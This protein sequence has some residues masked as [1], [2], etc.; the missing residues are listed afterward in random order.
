[1]NTLEQLA[2]LAEGNQQ[3]YYDG[4]LS[5][6]DFKEL[7]GDLNILGHVESQAQQTERDQLCRTVLVGIVQMAGALT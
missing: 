4:N 1:M 3:Q 5:A 2:T 6:E 7:I